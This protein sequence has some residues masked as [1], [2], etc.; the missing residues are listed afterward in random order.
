[1]RVHTP[2][3]PELFVLTL[4]VPT[5]FSQETC[6]FVYSTRCRAYNLFFCP[7]QHPPMDPLIQSNDTSV[8]SMHAPMIIGTND[9]FGCHIVRVIKLITKLC[10]FL[11]FFHVIAMFRITT[12]SWY[13]ASV[14][15]LFIYF[16]I[17][18][19]FPLI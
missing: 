1:M 5:Y 16:F 19:F 15:Y 17:L 9:V 13:H 3:T 11:A 7:D 10:M 4:F 2:A 12:S 6:T 14:P 18:L 8:E